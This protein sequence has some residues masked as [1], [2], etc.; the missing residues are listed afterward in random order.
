MQITRQRQ[1]AG[2]SRPATS[3]GYGSQRVGKT[4]IIVPMQYRDDQESRSMLSVVD[5]A[6]LPAR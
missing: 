4:P 1:D 6:D 3:D 5:G 2:A